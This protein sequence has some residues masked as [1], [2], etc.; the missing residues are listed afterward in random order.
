MT[1]RDGRE[2]RGAHSASD[3]EAA[4]AKKAPR[5]RPI[6]PEEVA[7]AVAFFAAAEAGRDHRPDR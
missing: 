4:L 5:G 3:G 2:R 1:D 6:E 7:F